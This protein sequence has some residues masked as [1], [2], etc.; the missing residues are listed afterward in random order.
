MSREDI[1]KHIIEVSGED[2]IIS[3]T[4]KASRELFEAR[5]ASGQGHGY[6][7][8]T[9]GSMGHTSSIAMGVALNKPDKKVW[10]ID[11]DG[12]AIMHLGALAV[13]AKHNPENMV[14]I[15]INNESH[16]TVGGLPTVS[17]NIDWKSLAA[18]AGFKWVSSVDNFAD[19]DK[20][21]NEAKNANHL[22]FIEVKCAL[23][24]RDD[25]GRPTTT[26]LENKIAFM[27]QLKKE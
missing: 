23:G 21:L 11:G 10:C 18:G 5:E 14:Y 25:L 16:E 9:V 4:G 13:L 15:L 2:P 26:A 1:I 17:S 22:S 12:S 24:A 3:T 19:L 6:D 20:E 7:F 8:L 27:D